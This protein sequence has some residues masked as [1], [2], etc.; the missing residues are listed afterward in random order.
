MMMKWRWLLCV[1][2]LATASPVMAERVELA[3]GEVLIA[4]V[5]EQDGKNVVLQHP[6]LGRLVVPVNQIKAMLADDAV[7]VSV[8]VAGQAAPAPKAT[9]VEQPPAA[10]IEPATQTPVAPAPAGF[11][12]NWKPKLELGLNGTQGN[13]E[14]TNF[15]FGFGATKE[16][17][18]DRWEFAT[19]YNLATDSGATSRNDGHARVLKDWLMHGSPWFVFARGRVDFDEFQDWDYRISGSAGPGYILVDEPKLRAVV[20]AGLGGQK[21]FGSANN[22]IVPEGSFGGEVAWEFAK[23]HKLTATSTWYQDVTQLNNYRIRSE[24]A[25]VMS[26]DAARG[27]SLKLALEDEYEAQTS[28]GSKNND[29]KYFAALVFEF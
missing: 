1:S 19:A 17:D 26:I 25:W 27:L 16:T 11:F 29:L 24:A 9:A 15:R 3:T 2:V 22:E 28:A 12:D 10:P 20:R 6:L 23:G 18:E 14:T 5:V 4:P 8:V 21:E 13:S 7:A